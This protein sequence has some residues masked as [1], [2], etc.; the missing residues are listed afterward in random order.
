[1]ARQLTR[2]AFMQWSA[3]SAGATLLAACAPVAAPGGAGATQ[4]AAGGAAA[5][6][7]GG[8]GTLVFGYPQKTTYGN[9]C[10]PWNGGTI[11][12]RDE[13]ERHR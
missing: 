2:R 13:F 1:M 10:V 7:T 12:K 11:I 3:M 9:L 8:G 5:Q 4:P 6:T